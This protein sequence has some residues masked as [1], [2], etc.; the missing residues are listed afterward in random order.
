MRI[1]GVKAS[2]VALVVVLSLL[3]ACSSD[4]DYGAETTCG[5]YLSLPNDQRGII[6]RTVG[7]EKGWSDASNPII[8]LPTLDTVC[9][10]QDPQVTVGSVVDLFVD[11]Q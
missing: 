7:Q 10:Q 9:G 2:V 3:T 8:G 4:P 1:G 6:V 5:E 11:N